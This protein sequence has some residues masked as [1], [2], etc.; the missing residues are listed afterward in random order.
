[1]TNRI[2]AWPW[3]Q[4]RRK[5]DSAG[6]GQALVECSPVIIVI[7]TGA[8]AGL[9]AFSDSV[10]VLWVVVNILEETFS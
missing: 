9:L 10:D 8:M 2:P 1:M 5:L 3:G 4:R 6:D 7:L